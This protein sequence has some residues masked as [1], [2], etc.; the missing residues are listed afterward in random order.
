MRV[1]QGL[2]YTFL[3]FLITFE[4]VASEQQKFLSQR[5]LDAVA[6]QLITNFERLDAI[7][8]DVRNRSRT[9]KWETYKVG[10]ITS[11]REARN[12]TDFVLAIDNFHYGITNLHSY[13]EVAKEIKTLSKKTRP[14]WPA[15]PLGYTYPDI[16][17][18]DIQTGESIMS[19]N[20]L[21][22]TSIFETFVNYYCND[23]HQ[24]GCL[25]SFTRY[26]GKGYR[27]AEN[28]KKITVGYTDASRKTFDKHSPSI[29][30]Y[31]PSKGCEEYLGILNL[32]LVF[33]G[34]QS[35]LFRFKKNYLLKIL[36]FRDWGN[37]F[38][39]I[40][41]A[42]PFE[43]G[44]CTD[45]NS[46]ITI[47]NKTPTSNLLIDLQ[48]NGGGSENTPWVAALTANGFM[49]N[50]VE[51]KNI[52]ESS[53]TN[54]RQAM[55][56]GSNY[57]E[58]WFTQLKE[59]QKENHFLPTRADFCRGSDLCVPTLIKSHPNHI[60]FSQLVL[61]TNSRCVSSCDDLV[62]RLKA[63]SKA[64]VVGQTPS[65]DGA[66]ARLMINIIL[67]SNGEIE[68]MISGEGTQQ[69]F[70]QGQLLL[71]YLVPV[72]RTVT[73]N[74]IRLDGNTNVLDI[75]FDVNKSNYSSINVDN[76]Q[77]ALALIT[78]K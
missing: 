61:I 42:K 37:N 69:N 13:V 18:F 26:M 17:F 70:D 75:L 51:Y 9:V 68:S 66:Y 35:C 71:S 31:P 40:Y 11:I 32:E 28:Q 54:I 63:Y 27:F 78:S 44:M 60:E 7:S 74:N 30:K 46:I 15:I 21:S 45:I 50:L 5:Q 59:E 57:A 52:S 49:D 38:H 77:R 56:Y 24:Q 8:I 48:N 73:S 43:A 41:C 64:K 16:S 25:N 58:D 19:L 65:T 72:S 10:L 55:F 53:Q 47:I 3:L 14:S 39:D 36:K 29:V 33:K 2:F 6:E 67:R 62:W 1:T 4:S 23:L 12:W 20:G 76:I 22:I 34:T